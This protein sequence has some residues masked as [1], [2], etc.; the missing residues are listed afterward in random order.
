M[1]VPRDAIPTQQ[2]LLPGQQLSMNVPWERDDRPPPP[3]IRPVIAQKGN[4]FDARE[5]QADVISGVY[6]GDCQVIR[7]LIPGSANHLLALRDTFGRGLVPV[8]MRKLD[9]ADVYAREIET[10]AEAA[11]KL[12]HPHLAQVFPCESTDEGIFWVTALVSGATL[13]EI[14][15]AC[16]KAG[17][18]VPVGIALAAVHEAALAL[19]ALH[20]PPGE[21]HALLCDQSLVVGFDGAARLLDVGLFRALRHSTYVLIRDL[22]DEVWSHTVVHSESGRMTFDDWL[23]T[24]E[25]HVP[26]HIAQMRAIYET[27]RLEQEEA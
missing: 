20:A 19:S 21:A 9:V 26:E 23:H 11:G 5:L 15:D 10:Y 22:P 24:Y 13:A 6:I 17:K 3:V 25:R 27:W 12:E 2:V 8:V 7:R 14:S 16:V 1:S 18:A 4:T